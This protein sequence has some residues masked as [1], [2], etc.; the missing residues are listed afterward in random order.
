MKRLDTEV[1]A[2]SIESCRAAKA[3][4]A[5]RVELCAG[6]AE[7]GVTPSAAA[8]RMARAIEGLQLSVMVRP[9]GGDF[10]YTD[11]EFEQMKS[12][13]LFIKEC[14]ADCAVFG[15]L[16][17]EGN[18]DVARTRE[19]VELAAPMQVT[20]HRAF[21]MTVDWHTALED[22]IAAGCHR[23]LTSGCRNTAVEG[24]DTLRELAAKAAGRIEI[25]AGSGVKPVNA[26]I[27]ARTGV[28]ALHFSAKAKRDS[29]MVFRNPNVS[30]GGNESVGEYDIEYADPA[31][32]AQIVNLLK[33]IR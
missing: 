20:F 17:P 8:I 32:I 33:E 10:L 22:V 27:L 16:T 14:G 21:D 11:E 24:I 5:T 15:L 3:G 26:E 12:E 1:C 7:G 31:T 18:V 30:M 4:G 29:G 6:P 19:L 25:M 28:D 13:V 9:R 2:Y 23:I